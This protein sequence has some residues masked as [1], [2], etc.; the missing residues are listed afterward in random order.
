MKCF[1]RFKRKMEVGGTSLRDEKRWNSQKLLEEVFNDGT[2]IEEIYFWRN[3]ITSYEDEELIKVRLYNEKYSSANGD[4]IQFQSLIDTPII[5]GDVIYVP[6]QNRYYLCTE[7]FIIDQVHYEGKLTLCNWILKWQNK[8]GEIFEYPCYDIN[9]TQYN[10]GEQPF[11]QFTIGSS[12]H[13]LLL[14]CDENTIVL[15]NP[16]RFFLDKNTENPTS[17]ILTQN[18]T[19]TYNIGEKG[20]VRL[21]LLECANNSDKDR[22]DLGICDYIDFSKISTDNAEDT[23]ISK[24]VI[25]YS[26]NIIKSGGDTQIFIGKFYDDFG[27]EIADVIS[28][29]N[30]ICDFKDKLSIQIAEN[31]ITIGTEDDSCIDEDFRLEFSDEDGNYLSELIVRIESLL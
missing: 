28:K 11:K 9:A 27:N 12:Q 31:K 25:S 26:T 17:Y 21:T 14:P 20:I 16:K 13:M 4:N 6:N 29:W 8:K 24:S 22:I 15:N 2:S 1:D 19:T 3:D 7:S 18:D 30:I 23:Y 5:V 10:S